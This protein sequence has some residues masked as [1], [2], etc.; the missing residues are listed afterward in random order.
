MNHED[1]MLTVIQIE[2]PVQQA[3]IEDVLTDA[4]ILYMAKSAGIQ[5]LFG[6]GQIGGANLITG[7]V[8][9][10]VPGSEFDRAKELIENALDGLEIE[11]IPTEEL[12]YEEEQEESD[13]DEES[14]AESSIEEQAAKYSKYSVVWSVLW[15]FGIGSLIAICYGVIALNLLKGYPRSMKIKA[16]FGV[17]WGTL[18]LFIWFFIWN[19]FWLR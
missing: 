15:A 4:N 7:P 16:I 10:Q 18:G 12:E 1:E 17:V 5:N 6:V 14:T 2:N 13:E 3:L 8:E 9:I 11:G 19:S